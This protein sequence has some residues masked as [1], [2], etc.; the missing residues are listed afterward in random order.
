MADLGTS[1]GLGKVGTA[2]LSAFLASLLMN[3]FSLHGVNFETLGFPSELVKSTL[4]G[5]FVGFFTWITPNHFVEGVIDF[6]LFLRRAKKQINDA[7]NQPLDATSQGEK[8]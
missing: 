1:G 8:Q 6:I 4:I 2:I 5:G 7:A 3:W